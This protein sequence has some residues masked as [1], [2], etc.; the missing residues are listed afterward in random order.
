MTISSFQKLDV[1]NLAKEL[2]IS[3]YKLTLQN[4]NFQSDKRLV[5]QLCSSALSIP[6]NIA[7][8][9][10]L[11]SIKQSLRHFYI[12][13]GSCAELKTQLII[14]YEVGFINKSELEELDKRCTQISKMLYR[15]IEARTKMMT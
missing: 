7:E 12:A 5:S 10:E 1:W 6:S 2:A 11:M 13:R 4:S 8:G 3:I 15:L 14:S 9:D